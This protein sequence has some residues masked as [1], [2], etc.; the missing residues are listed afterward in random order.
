MV[1]QRHLHGM[2]PSRRRGG[3]VRIGSLLSL[4][5]YFTAAQVRLDPRSPATQLTLVPR[6]A[7]ML[8]R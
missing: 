7:T 3:A 4:A 6:C 1:G 2:R 8:P 5:V